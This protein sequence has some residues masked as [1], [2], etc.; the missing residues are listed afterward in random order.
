MARHINQCLHPQLADICQKA[1]QLKSLQQQVIPLL[2]ERL[3]AFCQVGSFYKGCLVITTSDA[4]WASQL[5]FLMPELRDRL[6]R[7]GLYQLSSIKI[8][9]IEQV[10]SME[11]RKSRAP[12][13]LSASTRQQILSQCEQISYQPLKNALKK[14][15]KDR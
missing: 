9:L 11:S 8:A 2:P 4:A 12:S 13:A 5:R 7:K 15:A 1:L 3:Q 6:R 10:E 14:L